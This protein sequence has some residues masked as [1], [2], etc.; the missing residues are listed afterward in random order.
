MIWLFSLLTIFWGADPPPFLSGP[1]EAG[2][3]NPPTDGRTWVR[4]RSVE[5]DGTPATLWALQLAE[6]DLFKAG[7]KTQETLP[8]AAQPPVPSDLSWLAGMKYPDIPVVFD[9]TVITYLKHFRFNPGGRA[10]IRSWIER[11]GQYRAMILNVLARHKMPSALM[12]IAMIESGFEVVTKSS[13]G[14]LGLWQFMPD[15]ARVYGLRLSHFMDQRLDPELS[16]EAV[17][18]YFADLKFRFHDWHVAMAAYNCGYGRMLQS[19]RRYQS[20]DFWKLQKFENALPRETQLY[21]AKW[22]AVAI[23]DLNRD[24]FLIPKPA[25]KP[26]YAFEAVLAPGGMTL[27]QVARLAGV[28]DAAIAELNPE[29]IRRRLPP[30]DKL[31]R[32]RLPW[33]RKAAFEAGLR[34]LSPEWA[35]FQ[36]YRVQFGDTLDT[37]AARF[38]TTTARL[39]SLNQLQT[40]AEVVPGVTLVVPKTTKL[41]EPVR[42][43]LKTP[44]VAVPGDVAVPDGTVRLFYRTTA[45]DTLEILSDG[46]GVT[47]ENL[48]TWN[49]LNPESALPSGMVLQVFLAPSAAVH[50]ALFAA[51]TVKVVAVDGEEFIAHY[52]EQYDRVRILHTLA[53]N[54][55]LEKVAEKYGTTVSAIRTI[56]KAHSF[57]SG[58]TIIVYAKKDRAPRKAPVTPSPEKPEEPETGPLQ[59]KE[60][61]PGLEPVRKPDD[62]ADP[63]PE[64]PAA[65][66]PSEKPVVPDMKVEGGPKSGWSRLLADASRVLMNLAPRLSLTTQLKRDQLSSTGRVWTGQ[67]STAK[68]PPPAPVPE[69]GQQP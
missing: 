16:T 51:E 64:K 19:I 63:A 35:D 59:V 41:E 32:V 17:M 56:N 14:A 9:E 2:R 24:R 52:L 55:K 68:P 10:T 39:R 21:V 33:G 66:K 49:H 37:V 18:L 44:F 46:L 20:N 12:Y 57:A 40:S 62:P 53:P 38:G 3:L 5:P 58:T 31:V 1:S 43:P 67:P 4:G 54:Q 61:D 65:E 47:Q 69:K 36:V 7:E 11:S 28:T 34:K 27:T 6:E 45:G 23:A 48:I 30:A 42:A 8:V 60:P 22:I 26:A 29:F 15:G 50:K 13:A 25:M